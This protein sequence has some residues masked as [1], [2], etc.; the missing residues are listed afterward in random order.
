ME[1][2]VRDVRTIERL[3]EAVRQLRASEGFVPD[4]Q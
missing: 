4:L 2:F 3:V 1:G